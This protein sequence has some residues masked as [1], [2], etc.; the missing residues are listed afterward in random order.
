MGKMSLQQH[1]EKIHSV[2]PCKE[3]WTKDFERP[4]VEVD[5]T[6]IC[7]DSKRRQPLF[8]DSE[9]WDKIKIQ[10]YYMA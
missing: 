6:I 1:I 10:G 3:E 9:E 2:K 7:G 4:F 8:I 5:I